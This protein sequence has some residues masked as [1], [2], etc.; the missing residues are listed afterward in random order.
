MFNTKFIISKYKLNS[1]EIQKIKSLQNELETFIDERT[2]KNKHDLK[3][4]DQ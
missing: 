2:M 4:L 1:D 3:C